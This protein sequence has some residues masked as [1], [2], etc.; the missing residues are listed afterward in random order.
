VNY[1]WLT[2]RDDKEPAKVLGRIWMPWDERCGRYMIM[3][4]MGPLSLYAPVGDVQDIVDG[5]PVYPIEVRKFHDQVGFL[6]YAVVSEDRDI[7]FWRKIRGFE[8][9]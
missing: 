1:R 7:E 6:E 5:A 4:K 3:E 9:A 8:E 2:V